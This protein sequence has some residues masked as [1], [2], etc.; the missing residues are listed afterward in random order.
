MELIRHPT[1]IKGTI[2]NINLVASLHIG[3][4]PDGI[5]HRKKRASQADRNGN[6]KKKITTPD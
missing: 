5:S 6:K 1:W 2:L 4:V 3:M